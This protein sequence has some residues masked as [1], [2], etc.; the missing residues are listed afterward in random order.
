MKEGIIYSVRRHE[1][2]SE[3]WWPLQNA[4]IIIRNSTLWEEA[5]E[6]GFRARGWAEQN[7]KKGEKENIHRGSNIILC[8]REELVLINPEKRNNNNLLIHSFNKVRENT[9]LELKIQKIISDENKKDI[10]NPK[11]INE[12]VNIFKEK[13]IWDEAFYNEKGVVSRPW[14]VRGKNVKTDNIYEGSNI[15]MLM[16]DGAVAVNIKND[17]L[18]FNNFKRVENN[19]LKKRVADLLIENEIISQTRA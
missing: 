10:F 1:G 8:V 6:F 2:Q 7:I 13:G 16:G 4:G 14:S 3:E 11:N 9:D 19:Q 5:F 15:F 17:K 12:I 18:Q